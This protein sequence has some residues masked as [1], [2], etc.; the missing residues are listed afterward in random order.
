MLK[1]LIAN[2]KAVATEQI[3]TVYMKDQDLDSV[4][5]DEELI[6]AVERAVGRYTVIGRLGRQG[7]DGVFEE[8]EYAPL[9]IGSIVSG[10]GELGFYER[11]Q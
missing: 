11:I 7:V 3:P 8:K 6:R 4:L 9:D 2:G 5:K 10:K 1:Y